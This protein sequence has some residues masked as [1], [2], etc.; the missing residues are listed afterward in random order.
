VASSNPHEGRAS[1]AMQLLAN[2]LMVRRVVKLN[3]GR[4]RTAHTQEKGLKPWLQEHCIP[5]VNPAFVAA[6]EDVLDL[7]AERYDPRRAVV[8]FDERP[9]QLQG[10]TRAPLAVAPGRV[11]RADYEY[12]RNH[13][14]NVFITVEPL[15]GWRH[16]E[17]THRRTTLDFA[18][19]VVGWWTRRI[20]THG[21]FGSCWTT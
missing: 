9:L 5:E 2:E 6:M 3:L 17:L 13:T 16:V 7:Y 12:R 1:W 4:G 15:A 19:Q 10:D 14:A 18:Q 20:P 21:S 8:G 11:H